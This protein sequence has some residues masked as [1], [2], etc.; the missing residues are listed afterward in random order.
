[1]AAAR[2]CCRGARFAEARSNGGDT[3]LQSVTAGSPTAVTFVSGLHHLKA[4]IYFGCT[5]RGIDIVHT[6]NGERDQGEGLLTLE[7]SDESIE[8]AAAAGRLLSYDTCY[9]P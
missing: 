5:L 8:A 7:I 6:S 9:G 1:M 2:T 3:P 4:Q